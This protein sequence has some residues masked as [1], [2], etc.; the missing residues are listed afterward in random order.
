MARFGAPLDTSRNFLTAI[1][2]HQFL[3]ASA[4]G[5]GLIL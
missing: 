3:S 4:A 5:S 2:V 1:I